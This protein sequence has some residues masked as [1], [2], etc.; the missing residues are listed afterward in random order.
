MSYIAV[1]VNDGVIEGY[2]RGLDRSTGAINLSSHRSKD[3]LI[4]G[5]G[6]KT[7][8]DFRKFTV[9]RLGRTFE[10]ARET[11]TWH[12]AACT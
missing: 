3:A 5:I 2:F 6:V 1:T 12:G 7:A 10:I 8:K 4:R 9:D 11:R